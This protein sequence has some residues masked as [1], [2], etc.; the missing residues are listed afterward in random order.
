MTCIT[1]M[2]IGRTGFVTRHILQAGKLIFSLMKTVGEFFPNNREFSPKVR[3]SFPGRN[4]VLCEKNRE[5]F[6]P[7]K[8]GIFF[9]KSGNF[10]QKSGIFP[11]K[12]GNFCQMSGIFSKKSGI[13]SQKS[14]IFFPGTNNVL[15][16]NIMRNEFFPFIDEFFY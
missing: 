15:K 8:S 10:S 11:Q 9:H 1:D 16:R 7:Q 2:Y 14:G 13:F 3:D 12:S 5:V 6:F 4:L